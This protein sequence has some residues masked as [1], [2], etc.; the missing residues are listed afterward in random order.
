MNKQELKTE[1]GK[2]AFFMGIAFIGAAIL[3]ISL[4]VAFNLNGMQFTAIPNDYVCMPSNY[5]F[6]QTTNLTSF[7]LAG[8]VTLPLR[9]KMED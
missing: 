7:P 3:F 2:M 5:S 1:I 8:N 9:E 6:N 4:I